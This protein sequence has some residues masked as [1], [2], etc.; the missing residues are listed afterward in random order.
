MNIFPLIHTI[1]TCHFEGLCAYVYRVNCGNI[2]NREYGEW[3]NP[4]ARSHI[5]EDIGCARSAIFYGLADK[6]LGFESGDKHCGADREF[7]VVEFH[8]SSG[9]FWREVFWC[10]HGEKSKINK[11]LY[12]SRKMEYTGNIPYT[13]CNMPTIPVSPKNQVL[14]AC[15]LLFLL[16]S[17]FLAYGIMKGSRNDLEVITD[18]GSRVIATGVLETAPEEI[19]EMLEKIPDATSS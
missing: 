1:L 18:T 4:R 6:G 14:L 8:P 15:L 5:D 9:V 7:L 10:G 11:I 19:P 3:N 13:S 12:V 17:V 16:G 2:H